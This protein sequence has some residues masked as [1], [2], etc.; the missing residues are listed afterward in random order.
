MT[1]PS[2]KQTRIERVAARKAAG[3]WTHMTPDEVIAMID[4][5]LEEEDVD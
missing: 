3:D 5:V 1:D 4:A 2:R